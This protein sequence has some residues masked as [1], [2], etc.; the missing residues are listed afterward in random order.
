MVSPQDSHTARFL[1]EQLFQGPLLA[2][3][4]VVCIFPLIPSGGIT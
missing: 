3:R 1:F 2:N 4:T